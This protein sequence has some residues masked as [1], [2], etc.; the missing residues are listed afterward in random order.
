MKYALSGL[1][2]AL[3]IG[4]G[5][6]DGGSQSVT[7]MPEPVVVKSPT[8]IGMYGEST[9]YGD[10]GA[11]SLPAFV[12]AELG[13]TYIVINEGVP[14]TTIGQLITGTD[15]KHSDWDTEMKTTKATVIAIHFGLNEHYK[16]VPVSKTK[17]DLLHAVKTA[18]THG[19]RVVLQ[20]PNKDENFPNLPEIV[21][22]IREVA[23]AYDCDLVD[24]Y[25]LDLHK[26]D[27]LHPD[28]A[29][30]KKVASVVVK[31]LKENK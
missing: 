6:G 9:T 31:H 27:G 12:Q 30:Y 13:N 11:N 5:G 10:G 4:C 16:K 19:K 28:S 23:S 26:P 2:C 1:L 25:D 29:S 20:T 15:G 17:E 21:K 8:V 3:L 22:V 7:V 24:T 14:S 18:K